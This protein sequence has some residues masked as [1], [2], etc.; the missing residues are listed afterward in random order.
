[1]EVF[2]LYEMS[3]IHWIMQVM[4]LLQ[5]SLK[6]NDLSL[7][8]RD[9]WHQILYAINFFLEIFSAYVD[10]THINCR[11]TYMCLSQKI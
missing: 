7:R 9:E 6:L 8:N 1:V 11:I 2:K 4:I 5:S 10:S 3:F